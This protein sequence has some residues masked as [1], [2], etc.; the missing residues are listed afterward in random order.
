MF[1]WFERGSY[2]GIVFFLTLT[3]IGLPVPEEVPIVAAGVASRLAQLKWYYALPACMV[4]AL[5]GDSLMYA[6]G[7]FF[8]ARILKEHPWWSGFLTPE[9]ERTIENLLRKHG[10]HDFHTLDEVILE[11]DGSLSITRKGEQPFEF[12]DA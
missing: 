11:S 8:G 6:I 1:D 7:R 5:L 2:L 3:G 12:Q 10:I 9:R 4:G